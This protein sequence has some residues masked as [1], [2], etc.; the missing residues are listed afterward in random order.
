MPDAHE[1]LWKHMEQ[2][3]PDELICFQPHFFES[4]VV[5]TISIF[6]SDLVLFCVDDAMVGD[7]NTVGKTFALPFTYKKVPVSCPKI[8][9]YLL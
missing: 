5:L 8:N 9:N 7:S 6:K 2:E 4:V 3:T 1:S